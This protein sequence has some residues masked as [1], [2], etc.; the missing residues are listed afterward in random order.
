MKKKFLKDKKSSK[1]FS[2]CGYVDNR[3]NLIKL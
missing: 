3:I 2:N 1:N